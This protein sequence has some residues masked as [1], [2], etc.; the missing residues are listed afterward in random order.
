M[1]GVWHFTKLIRVDTLKNQFVPVL[2]V[3]FLKKLPQLVAFQIFQSSYINHEESLSHNIL[4]HNYQINIEQIFR[5]IIYITKKQPNL[6]A[7]ILATKF[8]FVPDCLPTWFN[9]SID[10]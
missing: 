8:G 2:N 10:K 7:K 6:V 5:S 4:L 3:N 1:N 9:P